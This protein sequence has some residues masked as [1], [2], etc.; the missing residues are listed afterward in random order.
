MKKIIIV[1]L[2]MLLVF[3]LLVAGCN[4]CRAKKGECCQNGKCLDTGVIC[5]GGTHPEFKGCNNM[6]IPQK[7]CTPN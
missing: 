2:I 7:V 1:L 3:S 4:S 6:C 5:L